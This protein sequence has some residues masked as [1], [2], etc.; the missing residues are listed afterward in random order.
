LVAAAKLLGRPQDV[1][2]PLAVGQLVEDDPSG[3]E[4]LV[5][6]PLELELRMLR[7]PA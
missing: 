1:G 6:E 2:G 7:K 3:D 5:D 4:R